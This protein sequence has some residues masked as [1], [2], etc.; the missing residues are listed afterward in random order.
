MAEQQHVRQIRE[1][2]ERQILKKANVVGVGMGYKESLGKPTDQLALVVLVRD[3]LPVHALAERDVVPQKID[4]LVTDVKAVGKVV[5]Y[6]S[7]VDRWR[8]AVGGISCGHYAI[9]AG[10]LGAV[11]RDA[12]TDEL[13]ILSNNHVLAN[14]NDAVIG[15]N[16]VQPGPLDGGRVPQDV[17]AKLHRFVRLRYKGDEEENSSCVLSKSIIGML[18]ALAGLVGSGTRFYYRP[19]FVTNLVDAAIA[20][21][22][23]ADVLKEEIYKVGT[24]SGTMEAKIGLEVKKCGRTTEFTTGKVSV[25]DT[26]IEV[27]Y[28]GGRVAVFEHQILTTDMSEPGDSG[29]LI[30]GPDNKAVGLLFAGSDQVTVMSPIETVLEK[31]RIKI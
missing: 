22:V 29:S 13:M 12:D 1:K 7:T 11:V 14:S 8:P 4:G 17:I 30:V 27:G 20:R 28:G 3:K 16:I 25:L 5:A 10:T 15:D 19:E 31:L 6:P 26:T 23:D 21:P 9:T 2:N 18:N 24:V